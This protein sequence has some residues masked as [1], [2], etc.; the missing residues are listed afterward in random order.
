MDTGRDLDRSDRYINSKATKYFLRANDPDKALHT[1]SLFAKPPGEEMENLYEMQVLWYCLEAGN[2]YHRKGDYVLALKYLNDGYKH[3][4][5]WIDDQLDYHNYSA[6]KFSMRTYVDFLNFEDSLLKSPKFQQ[7]LISIILCCV[8]IFENPKGAAESGA[9]ADKKDSAE[10]ASKALEKNEDDQKQ[11][12]EASKSKSTSNINQKK[13]SNKNKNIFADPDRSGGKLFK[14]VANDPLAFAKKYLTLL[15]QNFPNSPTTWTLS[16]RLL[17]LQNENQRAKESL[18]KSYDVNGKSISNADII[19]SLVYYLSSPSVPDTDKKSVF[20]LF[21]GSDQSFGNDFGSTIKYLSTKLQS[22]KYL[23]I[24]FALIHG[25]LLASVFDNKYLGLGKELIL[26]TN[27]SSNT[28]NGSKSLPLIE[29]MN[30]IAKIYF[31][32]DETTIKANLSLIQQK[33]PKFG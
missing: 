21:F 11:Q 33:F 2:A 5:A 22:D 13:K 28:S 32:S 17:M 7:V 18:E 27:Y 16:M 12:L 6:R 3:F 26:S 8:S 31:I 4:M 19:T 10:A 23:D 24:H 15:Q 1:I 9:N 14:K 20:A 25:V 29:K 30:S